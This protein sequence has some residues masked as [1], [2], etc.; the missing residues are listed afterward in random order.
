MS[1]AL[2]NGD[3]RAQRIDFLDVMR[4]VAILAVF[5]FHA[6][7]D[8]HRFQNVFQWNQWQI[9]DVFSHPWHEV[10]WFPLI[11]GTSGVAIFFAISGFCIHISYTRRPD[12][13]FRDF[14]IRRV[15]RIYPPYLL[16]LLVFAFVYPFGDIDLRLPA[17]ATNFFAHLFLVH[18]LFELEVYAGINPS[19]WSIA[20]EAQLYALF[21]LMFLLARWKGWRT[22]LLVCGAIEMAIRLTNLSAWALYDFTMPR[23]FG[24]SALSYVFSWSIGA[25]I[26][27]AWQRG[28][29]LPLS[30]TS[31]WFWLPVAIAC[32]VCRPLT[33]FAFPAC[34]VATGA[35][36]TGRLNGDLWLP[37][38]PGGQLI[39]RHLT[40]TGMVSYSFYL[41]HQPLLRLANPVAGRLLGWNFD[42]SPSIRVVL[43]LLT[44]PFVLG[45]SWLMYRFV[46]LPTIAAARRLTHGKDRRGT[47][48]SKAD[49]AP[50][51]MGH[52]ES[53]LST[54]PPSNV[55]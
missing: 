38:L 35:F 18:N 22:T 44:W 17:D 5:G 54:A 1:S 37:K 2:P 31:F 9:L 23:W 12:P 45:L 55:D 53:T 48:N 8:A 42:D 27:D 39:A 46:E 25:A 11:F 47:G 41:I 6:Y 33:Y 43:C 20:A 30:R 10:I 15:F 7:R 21:P 49:R 14:C 34:A 32:Y 19:F 13:Y 40:F 26:A 52:Q 4:G 36:I 28:E 16:A 50:S 3:R 24:H 29:R 51:L